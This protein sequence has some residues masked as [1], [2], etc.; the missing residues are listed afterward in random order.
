[1]PIQDNEYVGTVMY[2]EVDPEFTRN[3]RCEINQ[4]IVVEKLTVVE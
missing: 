4:P 1:M 2:Q 3:N